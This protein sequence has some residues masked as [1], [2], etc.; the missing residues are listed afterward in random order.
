MPPIREAVLEA[1]EQH[2]EEHRR[3]AEDPECWRELWPDFKH[4]PAPAGPLAAGLLHFNGN[5]QLSD[6][7]RLECLHEHLT[8]PRVTEI[9]RRLLDAH[10]R[11][12]QIAI[13]KNRPPSSSPLPNNL[14][15]RLWHTDWPHDLTACKWRSSLCAFDRE[16]SR[17]LLDADDPL[18]RSVPGSAMGNVGSVRQPFPRAPMALSTVWYF[19]DATPA[20]GGT[21]AMPG[22]FLDPRNPRGPDCGIDE[23]SPLEGEVQVN[24]PAGSVFI[25]DTRSW[26]S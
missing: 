10:I 4:S 21:M 25:Q 14:G 22:S 13:T 12:A 2:A 3:L 1:Q 24:A 7:C 6:L 19:A 23:W 17:K 8:S 9:A 20:T 11:I 15:Q 5:P 16:A 18:G 26:V